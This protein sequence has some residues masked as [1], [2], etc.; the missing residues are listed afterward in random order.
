MQRVN[1]TV[2]E[3]GETRIL[4]ANANHQQDAKTTDATDYGFDKGRWYMLKYPTFSNEYHAIATAVKDLDAV[5]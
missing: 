4:N 5:S 2:S 1:H 3:R